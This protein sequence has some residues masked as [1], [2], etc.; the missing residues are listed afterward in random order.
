M[1]CARC[2]EVRPARQRPSHTARGAVGT[3]RTA[4]RADCRRPRGSCHLPNQLLRS[5]QLLDNMCSL[6]R[7]LLVNNKPWHP[8][9]Y[10]MEAINRSGWRSWGGRAC[11]AEVRR[12]C[13]GR[14]R[15]G[16]CK[17]CHAAVGRKGLLGS[18]S[19]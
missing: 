8:P 7:D 13:H 4:D 14:S 1:L 17:E 2:G 12:L 5:H 9:S 18:D 3:V 10:M 19:V 6:R 15:F 11:N 16:P